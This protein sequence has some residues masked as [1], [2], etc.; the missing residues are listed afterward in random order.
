M[1]PGDP[2][3][4]RKRQLIKRLMASKGGGGMRVGRMPGM[5]GRG[6]LFGG[7]GNPLGLANRMASYGSAYGDFDPQGASSP[8]FQGNPVVSSPVQAGPVNQG[9]PPQV[10]PFLPG[11]QFAPPLLVQSTP[12]LFQQHLRG[13]GTRGRLFAQ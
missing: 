9:G 5:M 4:E 10:D 12:D 6:M 2:I 3:E 8:Q 11:P 1:L 7:G 13:Y